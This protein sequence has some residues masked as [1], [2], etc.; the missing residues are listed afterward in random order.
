MRL[1]ME[2]RQA[3]MLG[4]RGRDQSVGRRNAVVAIAASGKFTNRAGC[5]VCDSTVVAQAAQRVQLGLERDVFDDG[6]R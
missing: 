4:S 2:Y 6:A 5:G 1:V 3:A